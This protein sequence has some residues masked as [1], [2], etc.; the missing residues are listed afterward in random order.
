MNSGKDD[1]C[2]ARALSVA[3][4]HLLVAYMKVGC[5]SMGVDILFLDVKVL[6]KHTDSKI[7]LE[8]W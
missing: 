6:L 1:L 4:S 8:F 3:T 2:S 5:C 7:K